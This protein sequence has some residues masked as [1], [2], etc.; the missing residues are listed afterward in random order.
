MYTHIE[1]VPQL[2]LQFEHFNDI[3]PFMLPGY[4]ASMAV[5]FERCLFHLHSVLV[6]V[7]FGSFITMA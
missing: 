4:R 2:L 5:V 1:V 6:G 7:T 3:L